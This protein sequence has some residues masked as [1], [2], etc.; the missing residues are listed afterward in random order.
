MLFAI[1]IVD[2]E[3]GVLKVMSAETKDEA[4]ARMKQ[5]QANNS[6]IQMYRGIIQ[7]DGDILFKKLKVK[8]GSEVFE[9][10]LVDVD[11]EDA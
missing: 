7:P 11:F 1:Q 6:A 4:R 10:Q 3:P 5:Y 8:A 9:Q 2:A